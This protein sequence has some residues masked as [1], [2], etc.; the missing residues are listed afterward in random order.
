MRGGKLRVIG[1][2]GG[3]FERLGGGG[4]IPFELLDFPLNT[5]DNGGGGGGRL[6]VEE[7]CSCLIVLSDFFVATCV[8]GDVG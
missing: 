1:G 4:S 3:K 8:L 6:T 2:I 7:G 5:S